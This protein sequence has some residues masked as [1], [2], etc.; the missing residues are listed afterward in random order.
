MPRIAFIP[1]DGVGLDVAAEAEKVLEAVIDRSG[2]DLQVEDF[3]YGAQKYLNDGITLPEEQIEDFRRNYAA[4]FM[5]TLGDPRVPDGAHVKDILSKLRLKLDL[6]VNCRPITIFNAKYCPL[7]DEQSGSVDFIVFRENLEGVHAN[8][9]GVFRAGTPDEEIIQQAIVSR[10]GIVRIMRHAFEFARRNGRNKL[11][12][13]SGTGVT[14]TNTHLWQSVMDEIGSEFNTIDK[15]TEPL[16]TVLGKLL[17]RPEDYEIIVSCNL[18][19]DVIADIGAELQ[20]GVGL[21][22]EG[23]L[24]PGKISL[25]KPVHGPMNDKAG[26]NLINPLGSISAIAMMLEYLGFD[27]EARWVSTAVRYALDTDNTTSDLGG[28]LGTRQV[29]DFIADQIK[30]GAH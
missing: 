24:N 25:F 20:G 19:G 3:D 8:L 15:K 28:R 27:Q 7:K 21:A 5:G 4:I 1:G 12:V 13:C 6:Y 29:G 23:N 22:V 14:N 16:Q 18:F 10:R 9:G 26:S 2:L 17:R 11:T 30:K